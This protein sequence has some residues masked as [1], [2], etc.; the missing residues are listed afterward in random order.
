[1]ITLWTTGWLGAFLDAIFLVTLLLVCDETLPT[2]AVLTDSLT[3]DSDNGQCTAGSCFRQ[4]STHFHLAPSAVAPDAGWSSLDAVCFWDGQANVKILVW[5]WSSTPRLRWIACDKFDNE[6]R[7]VPGHC[8]TVWRM[9]S[10]LSLAAV[11][12]VDAASTW[13]SILHQ[14]APIHPNC[15]LFPF[16]STNFWV[17][18]VTLSVT[19]YLIMGRCQRKEANKEVRTTQ[20]ASSA[21][22][23]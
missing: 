4:R 19:Q 22:S 5:F 8:K 20:P 3:C 2:D 6:V 21:S 14:S 12:P 23:D 10:H 9:A 13:L 15:S 17:W 7:T 16:N 1:M 11:T 18:C